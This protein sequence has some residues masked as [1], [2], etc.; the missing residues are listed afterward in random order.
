ME[1][2][3]ELRQKLGALFNIL[4]TRRSG[5]VQVA[6]ACQWFLAA[7][8]SVGIP[9]NQERASTRATCLYCTHVLVPGDRQ[10]ANSALRQYEVA[11]S[12]NVSRA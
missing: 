3:V 8:N 9:P 10:R 6:R 2:F 7:A 11:H 4:D 1:N 5:H 12:E